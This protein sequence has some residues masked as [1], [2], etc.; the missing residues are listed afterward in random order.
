MEPRGEPLEQLA[1]RV[2]KHAGAILPRRQRGQLVSCIY[3]EANCFMHLQLTLNR[4]AYPTNRSG[5][6]LGRL[7]AWFS[8]S[9]GADV[10][11]H[12][13]TAV[14]SYVR[15]AAYTGIVQAIPYQYKPAT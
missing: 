14:S 4:D 1:A 6:S 2:R 8:R 11:Q 13:S 15:E 3:D 9:H 10:N 7:P 12:T 5:F